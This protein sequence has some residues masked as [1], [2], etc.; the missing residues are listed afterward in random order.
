MDNS[1]KQQLAKIPKRWKWLGIILS[2]YAL[3]G[4]LLLPWLISTT[5]TDLTQKR[6]QLASHIEKVRFNPFTFTLQIDQLTLQQPDG[7][8]FAGFD[9]LKVNFQTT[10]LF[11]WAWSFKEVHLLGLHS[12]IERQNETDNTLST[13]AQRWQASAEQQQTTAPPANANDTLPRIRISDIQFSIARI[14]LLDQVPATPFAT[15]LGPIHFGVSDF[16]TLPNKTGKQQF[17]FATE[18]GAKLS[19]SGNISL[20]PLASEGSVVIEGPYLPLISDYLQDTLNFKILAGDFD[21]DFNYAIAESSNGINVTIDKI[22]AGLHNLNL[23]SDNGEPLYKLKSLAVSNAIVEWPAQRAH[24]P[25][26]ALNNGEL[27]VSKHSDGTINL[28]QLINT[29]Q[30]SSAPTEKPTQATSESSTPWQVT[31]HKISIDDWQVQFNDNS[32]GSPAS[33]LVGPINISAKNIGTQANQLIGIDAILG[34]TEGSLSLN[35]ELQ[36][37]P[38]ANIAGTYSVDAIP[39]QLIQ[40]YLA[41]YAKVELQT[42]LLAIQG[43]LEG[44]T[45]SVI[46][47]RADLQISQLNII[48]NVTNTRLL[49]WNEL[50][51]NDVYA[52][53]HNNE[54]NIASIALSEMYADFVIAA[55][56]TT[57]IDRIM[58]EVKPTNTEP[59]STPSVT[60]ENSGSAME[61]TIGKIE[62]LESAG[63]FADLSLPLPFDTHI[64]K[65]HGELSTLASASTQPSQ[66]S[67]E[68]Q[69]DEYGLMR[70]NGYLSAMDPTKNSDIK[71]VFRNVNVPS[72]SP[73][74]IKFA[75][76]EVQS[77]KLDLNLEYKLNEGKMQANNNVVLYD[78]ALG[79]KLDQPGAVDLP[80]DLALALLK[81]GNGKIDVDLPITG[82]VNDPKFGIGKVAGQAITRLITN[83]VTS[84]FKLLA[85]LAGSSSEDIGNIAFDAGS[86]NITPPELEKI[87]ALTKALAQRPNLQLSIGAAFEP[88]LDGRALKAQKLD[89]LLIA[90]AGENSKVLTH[91]KTLRALE[92]LYKQYR[93]EP[94]L[95]VLEQSHTKQSQEGKQTVDTLAY[96]NQIKNKLIDQQPLDQTELHTL[97]KAR[98]QVIQNAI[99]EKNIVITKQIQLG[100]LEAVKATKQKQIVTELEIN[101][102]K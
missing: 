27:W 2:L 30:P 92:N 65:L 96:A 94:S 101:V 32:I 17:S 22:H 19:W 25:D 46:T 62:I 49:G 16:S 11:Y 28:T 1:P 42:G 13:L 21:I 48:E 56:S 79:K 45:P 70:A 50:N 72:F 89:A 67:L 66:L 37:N 52:A 64:T 41:D 57:T 5:L 14:N 59:E 54:V 86:S 93:L 98:A 47:T 82:D 44:E 77:G 95:N 76:R 74:S 88:K 99:T 24:I 34:V 9:K 40:P 84:P 4:F 97:A 10:S 73:Y 80:L 68:G 75:G 31:T 6:L 102:K 39:L 91:P 18:Q 43:T 78:L 83:I 7:S 55:D 100:E 81:D 23:V 63:H 69:V 3:A 87:H 61:V 33:I 85:S 51:V 26:I 58:V 53:P 60:D 12:T 90:E 36:I 38:V 20:A 15:Q 71:L 29:E 8:E 35:T